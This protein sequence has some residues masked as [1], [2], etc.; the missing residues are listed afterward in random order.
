[1]GV[2]LV[3]AFAVSLGSLAPGQLL[4]QRLGETA[5]A[6]RIRD[7]PPARAVDRVALLVGESSIVSR[8]R[9]CNTVCATLIGTVVGGAIGAGVMALYVWHKPPAER[10]IADGPAIALVAIGGG[11]VGG[12]IGFTIG[13][14]RR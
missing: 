10:S 11:L 6:G 4:G 14:S 7:R 8:E 2:I 12:V 9:R 13:F 5:L 1:M 3:C